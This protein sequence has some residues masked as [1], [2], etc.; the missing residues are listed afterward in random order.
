M[1]LLS[2][3]TDDYYPGDN[4]PER[5]FPVL[6]YCITLKDFFDFLLLVTQDIRNRDTMRTLIEFY[7]DC[8]MAFLKK[9]Q[10]ADESLTIGELIQKVRYVYSR[11]PYV[12]FLGELEEDVYYELCKQGTRALQEVL[13]FAYAA[14]FTECYDSVSANNFNTILNG[15]TIR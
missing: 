1:R 7:N 3:L 4:D 15:G 13:I 5:I 12:L 11:E 8:D 9:Y 14:C 6:F 10:S 2:G